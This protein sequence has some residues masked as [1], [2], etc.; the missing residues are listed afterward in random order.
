M[1]NILVKLFTFS[2]ITAMGV[3]GADESLGTWKLNMGKSK[4][5]P[6][7]PVKSLT[8]TRVAAEGGVKLA[9]TGEQA[10]GKQRS[11]PATPSNMMATTIRWPVLRGIQ[12]PSN[13]WI[14]IPSRR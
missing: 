9:T 11:T 8:T 13:R 12:F 2:V 5:N 10:D 3:F 14:Q 7:A 4:F 6:T 1:R